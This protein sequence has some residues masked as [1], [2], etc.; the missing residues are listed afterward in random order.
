MYVLLKMLDKLV[1]EYRIGYY[2]KCKNLRFIYLSFADDIFVFSDGNFR[3]IESIM[4][5][6]K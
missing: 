4:E 6:F 5:V 3:F 1:E 2:F